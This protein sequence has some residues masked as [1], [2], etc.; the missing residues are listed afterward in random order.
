MIGPV[1]VLSIDVA[2]RLLR[3]PRKAWDQHPR[4]GASRIYSGYDFSESSSNSSGGAKTGEGLDAAVMSL[5][6]AVYASMIA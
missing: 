5:C 4:D 6:R 2:M 1:N 3:L